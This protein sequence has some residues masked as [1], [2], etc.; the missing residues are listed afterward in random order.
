MKTGSMR[1]RSEFQNGYIVLLSTGPFCDIFTVKTCGVLDMK[2]YQIYLVFLISFVMSGCGGGS[3]SG[4]STPSPLAD[5]SFWAVDFTAGRY[6]VVNATKAGEGNNCY[7]YVENGQSVP[8]NTVND[9][10]SQFDSTIHPDENSAFGGEPNPGIDG[11]P[12]IYILLLNL[13]DG[14]TVGNPSYIAGYFDPTSEYSLTSQNAHSNQKEIIFMNINSAAGIN[15]DGVEFFA[16]ISH[17]FQHMIHWEQ[18]THQRG[19]T[20]AT[21]IDESMAQVARDFCG[22]G[23]DYD[24]VFAYEH[25]L[26][27]NT[28][29]SLVAFDESVGNYGMAYMWAQYMKDRF[30]SVSE[31]KTGNHLFWNM[32]HNT[33]TSITEVNDTL[34]AI[35]S[36]KTFATSFQDWGVANFY[37]N[38]A[39]YAAPQSQWSYAS[40]SFN[41][42]PGTYTFNGGQSHRTLPGLFTSSTLNPASLQ[43]LNQ[44]SV[45]YYSFAPTSSSPVTWTKG[46]NSATAAYFINGNNGG[47]PSDP[48]AMTT[49]IS[50][51]FAGTGYLIYENPSSTAYSAAQPSGDTIAHAAVNTTTALSISPSITAATSPPSA[52]KTPREMLAAYNADPTVRRYA[53]ETG[54]PFRVYVDSWFRGR[55]KELRTAGFRPPF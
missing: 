6:Y 16:T 55:E 29:H 33:S 2:R 43:P 46:A 39:T 24:S 40:T 10:I 5:G 44:W 41:T 47:I 14:F 30:D 13:R 38:G 45:A 19:L 34:T 3:S 7:I 1:F 23:P 18:K 53:Q 51:Q 31:T 48:V 15:P 54:K 9:I 52:P 49:G 27:V 4:S 37:G 17:E 42:W 12:K 11:D 36:G 25:D 32:L 28:N 26:A 22:Y 20:D 21:W 8:P 50:Y 35:S